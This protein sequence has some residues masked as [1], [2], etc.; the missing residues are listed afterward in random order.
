[1]LAFTVQVTSQQRADKVLDNTC[2]S[3]NYMKVT[4]G[5][6]GLHV[7]LLPR[8]ILISIVF[9]TKTKVVLNIFQQQRQY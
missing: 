6:A 1:M 4:I 3:E 7:Q 5:T 8:N 2:S 9:Q